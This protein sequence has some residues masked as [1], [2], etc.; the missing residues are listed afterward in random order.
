MARYKIED[1]QTRIDP[2]ALAAGDVLYVS[3]LGEIVRSDD[4]AAV[5]LTGTGAILRNFGT[6]E[7]QGAGFA[8][9]GALSGELDVTIRNEAGATISG[10]EGGIE[11]ESDNGTTG[12]VRLVNAGTIEGGDTR[13]V[14]FKDLRTGNIVIENLVGGL[15]TNAGTADVVRPGNDGDSFISI[16]NAGTILARV[17]AGETSGADAIDLQPEDG[18]NQAVIVNESTGII[19]GGKHGITGANTAFITNLGDGQI[20]GR[21]GSGINFDTEAADG[22]GAVYVL[23][24]G[25]ISGRYDGYGDGDGDGVDVDYLIDI[26]NYGTIEGVGADNVENFADGIAAGGGQIRNH[27]GATIHGEYNGI[28]IDDGDRN[29]AYAATQLNNQGTISADVGTGVQFIG[30]FADRIANG[31]TI[32]GPVAIDAGA[33]DDRITNTGTLSGDVLLG[34]GDDLFRSDV[35]ATHGLVDGGA[36]DDRIFSAAD[37][38]AVIGGLGADLISLSG[39]GTVL[40]Y[41]DVADSNRTTGVDRVR[42]SSSIVLDLSQI[43]ADTT[44]DGDQAFTFILNT[45]FTGTAGELRIKVLG[46]TQATLLGDVDGDGH[47]DLVINLSGSEGAILQDFV[48]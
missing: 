33:G 12:E 47:A 32:T 41:T 18:G 15:I 37:G 35:G 46:E 8:I 30:D 43:D 6:I 26:K 17:V 40:T 3:G 44:Q 19:E 34:D 42:F 27:A 7:T 4:S 24:Q 14:N 45:A 22:D 31:G 9:A 16:V 11:L 48:F 5:T 36:G 39:D 25:T 20:I 1:N 38:G 10:G 13:A 23:N 2:L 28:L 29:G 21:N